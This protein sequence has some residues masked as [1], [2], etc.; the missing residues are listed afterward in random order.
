VIRPGFRPL[1]PVLCRERRGHQGRALTGRYAGLDP[2][3]S[4]PAI[5]TY[6]RG[7]ET[8]LG[9]ALE[10]LNKDKIKVWL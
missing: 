6:G 4:L 1:R 8:P 7:T 3:A 10:T 2:R 9:L 5:N